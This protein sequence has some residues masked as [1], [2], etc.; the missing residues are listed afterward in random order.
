MITSHSSPNPSYT[1]SG[2][3][4][5]TTQIASSIDARIETQRYSL[6]ALS[7]GPNGREAIKAIG[8]K[9]L[10]SSQGLSSLECLT[11]RLFKIAPAD[12]SAAKLKKSASAEDQAGDLELQL[13]LPFITRRKR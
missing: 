3:V 2:Y 6:H 8:T 5:R 13:A 11:K 4:K 9:V 7:F 10:T 1:P 12:E